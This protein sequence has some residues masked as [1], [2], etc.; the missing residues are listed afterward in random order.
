[1]TGGVSVRDVD[2]DLFI[3]CYARFL[4]QS[5][6]LTIP[7]WV[8]VVKTGHTREMAPYDPDWYSVSNQFAAFN[9]AYWSGCTLEALWW[10]K[11]PWL[12]CAYM[13][14]RHAYNDSVG[15]QKMFC[16]HTM[17]VRQLTSIQRKALQSLEALGVLEKDS[18]GGRH[19]T[20]QGQRD[21]DHIALFALENKS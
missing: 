21:L 19:I 6:K 16:V 1:M 10:I 15:M 2:A 9:E 17:C 3:R 5:G 8:D 20:Q 18:R 11:K 13:R 14:S 4:K 12:K 7:N